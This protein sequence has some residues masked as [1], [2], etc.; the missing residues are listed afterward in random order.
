MRAADGRSRGRRGTRC[1]RRVDR[2]RGSRTVGAPCGTTRTRPAGAIPASTTML[3]AV[4]VKTR[5]QRGSVA[6]LPQHVRLLGGRL[7]QHGVQGDDERLVQVLDQGQHIGPG[8]AAED[9]VLVLDQHDVGAASVEQGRD[10]DV[11]GPDVLPDHRKDFGF[12]DRV[13]VADDRQ[14]VDLDGRV[15]LQQRRPKIARERSDAARARRVGR[16]HGNSHRHLSIPIVMFTASSGAGCCVAWRFPA[17]GWFKPPVAADG[18]VIGRERFVLKTTRRATGSVDARVGSH[19]SGELWRSQ[20]QV[21]PAWTSHRRGIVDP[22]RTA[23]QPGREYQPCAVGRTAA[24][25]ATG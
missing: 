24:A 9:A 13:V 2:P 10:G 17:A 14:D 19:C 23:V 5:D 25:S 3:R 12:L 20:G 8:L 22:A 15:G 4:S 21:H 18:P 11:I 1:R 6:E 16:D 7:G